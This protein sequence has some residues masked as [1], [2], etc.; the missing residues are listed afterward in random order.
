MTE[1]G[2]YE[3][4]SYEHMLS[5]EVLYILDDSPTYSAAMLCDEHV[6]AQIG[7]VKRTMVKAL[8]QRGWIH[9]E[10]KEM[11]VWFS[12]LGT[13]TGGDY[14]VWS[15]WAAES[16]WNYLWVSDYARA[17]I[18]ESSKRLTGDAFEREDH[19]VEILI[20]TSLIPPRIY[21]KWT[22]KEQK[23][24]YT[25]TPMPQG[26]LPPRYRIEGRPIWAFRDYY[27]SLVS[28]FG[29]TWHEGW[30]GFPGSA[31]VK[32][33]WERGR[34]LPFWLAEDDTFNES[35]EKRHEDILRRYRVLCDAFAKMM[36]GFY[37]DDAKKFHGKSKKILINEIK[38]KG[39]IHPRYTDITS[40]PDS[41][42]RRPGSWMKPKWVQNTGADHV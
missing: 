4:L 5:D 12:G 40:Y 1:Y 19:V 28:K 38:S 32:M 41:G 25:D 8:Q 34:G 21:D 3:N 27:A 29:S 36:D 39:A 6:E 10:L 9:E 18:H 17:L 42:F 15:R 2:G 11:G 22:K 35:L 31:N 20:E 14:T 33:S 23:A 7:V 30:G 13:T 16:S 24:T 26:W 37:S